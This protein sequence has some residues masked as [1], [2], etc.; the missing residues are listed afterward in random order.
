MS[1]SVLHSFG[2]GIVTRNSAGEIIE[3]YYPQPV[4]NPEPSLSAALISVCGP[5][6]NTVEIS[7][8]LHEEL[9]EALLRTS[10]SSTVEFLNK[11]AESSPAVILC[12]I[13]TDCPP[14]S[15]SE[16]YLKLHLLSHRLC[17]PHSLNLD[18]LF[19][20]LRNLA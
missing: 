20:V 1:E 17:K 7:D 5:E 13:V 19:G 15:I 16:A 2:F 8:V 6:N 11:L 10:E 3:V 12:L 9:A 14:Q 4:M 18:G